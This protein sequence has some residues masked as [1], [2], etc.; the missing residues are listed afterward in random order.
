MSDPTAPARLFGNFIW[1]RRPAFQ[2]IDMWFVL[3]TPRDL[4]K[5]PSS[6]SEVRATR[7]TE[8]EQPSEVEE[9]EIIEVSLSSLCVP[10]QAPLFSFEP[11]NLPR[12]LFDLHLY[13]IRIA[14]LLGH[15]LEPIAIYTSTSDD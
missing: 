2:A 1:R 7:K 4:K 6:S 11:E 14:Y 5:S 3:G 8:Q 13:P 9:E 12:A 15:G 10:C